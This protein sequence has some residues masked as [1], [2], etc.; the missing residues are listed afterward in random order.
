MSERTVRSLHFRP[1]AGLPPRFE[2]LPHQFLPPQ[3]IIVNAPS[4]RWNPTSVPPAGTDRPTALTRP[5]HR[6]TGVPQL[7]GH[8]RELGLHASKELMQASLGVATALHP[9]RGD[10][11]ARRSRQVSLI[12]HVAIA[13]AISS[14]GGSGRTKTQMEEI[15]DSP[16]RLTILWPRQITESGAMSISAPHFGNDSISRQ[17]DRS[18]VVLIIEPR[19]VFSPMYRI[20][21]FASRSAYCHR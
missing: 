5:R 17:R 1:Y 11:I 7:R 19:R 6:T 9:S 13:R 15:A 2:C 8:K 20:C 4:T 21:R 12:A 16:L 10:G 14:V 18:G 3:V